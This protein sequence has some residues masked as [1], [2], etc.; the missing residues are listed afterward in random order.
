[1]THDRQLVQ[2]RLTIEENDAGNISWFYHLGS[3]SLLSIPDMPMYHISNFQV[4]GC[5]LSVLNILDNVESYSHRLT[6]VVFLLQDIST[7]MRS[8]T[9]DDRRSHQVDIVVCN[10][11]RIG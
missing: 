11:F 1:M 5:I 8:S 6:P 9:I 10:S 7:G 3:S 2:T 4:P